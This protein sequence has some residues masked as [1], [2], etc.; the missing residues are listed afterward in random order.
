[1]RTFGTVGTLQLS[2]NIAPDAENSAKLVLHGQVLL[3]ST[4]QQPTRVVARADKT[5]GGSRSNASTVI[6]A[7]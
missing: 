2:I 7:T 5:G 6:D 4:L 3:I 1:M